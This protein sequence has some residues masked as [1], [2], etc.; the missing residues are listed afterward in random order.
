MK[1]ARFY[2]GNDIRVE[3]VPDPLPGPGEVLIR[4]RAA[5]ICGSD[6]HT[7]R[8]GAF[9]RFQDRVPLILGHELAGE[10]LG[11][12]PGIDDLSIGQ[13][14]A[15]EPLIGCGS[16]LYCQTGDYHIC[17]DLNHI[18]YYYPGGFAE[19]TVAPRSKV[20]PL[21]DNVEMDA[22]GILDV[23][24]CAVHAVHRVP[25][26]P[27]DDVLIIGGGAIGLTA[28]Q[29]A[30]AA[31]ARSLIVMATYPRALQVARD[32][33]AAAINPRYEDPVL[34]VTEITGGKGADVVIEAVGGSSNSLE[35]ALLTAARGGTVGVLGS[36]PEPVT[37]PVNTGLRSELDLR[38]IYSYSTWRGVPE[39]RIALDLLAEERVDA[40]P[41]ITHVFPLE[42]IQ[43]GFQAALNKDNSD[44]IKVMIHPS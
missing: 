14:V 20:F 34:A 2:T 44:A 22:A 8:R 23:Y 16:C 21:P 37:L 3:E 43:A 1:A 31:G 7:Y 42:E 15:V 12:G 35:I 11:L 19:K 39:F 30:K 29:V 25:I 5:G 33:G 9:N 6:L 41:L 17:R 28:A 24:A 4:V 32:M 40:R 10:V 38:W 18:G 36:F 13:R 26:S 27:L